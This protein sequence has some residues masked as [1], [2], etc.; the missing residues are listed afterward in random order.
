MVGWGDNGGMG[1]GDT[2]GQATPE[3]PPGRQPLVMRSQ[4]FCQR[5]YPIILGYKMGRGNPSS[6]PTPE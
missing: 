6:S 5:F 2:H 1:P 4:A 3:V